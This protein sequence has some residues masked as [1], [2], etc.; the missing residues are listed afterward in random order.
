MTLSEEKSNL[1]LSSFFQN[2]R[3]FLHVFLL[4]H[5]NIPLLNL[6]SV[7]IGIGLGLARGTG[8]T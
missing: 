7:N 5:K 3:H 2:F 8:H 4:L 1:S 6:K